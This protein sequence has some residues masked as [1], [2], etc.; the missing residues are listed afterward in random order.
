MR[1]V[2][3][4]LV[5]AG[6]FVTSAASGREPFADPAQRSGGVGNSAP[7]C[8]NV[9]DYGAVAD[10]RDGVGRDNTSAFQ[11]AADTAIRHGRSVC[12]PAGAYFLATGFRIEQ[13]D[14]TDDATPR[15]SIVGDG[16]GTTR[17]VFGPGEFAGIA[18]TA[19]KTGAGPHVYAAIRGLRLEKADHKGS[20]LRLTRTA[21]ISIE[22][23]TAVGW[24]VGLEGIDLLL[25]S[26][27]DV[28]L[29]FNRYGTTLRRG[30]FSQPN[31]VAF[32]DARID[33]NSECG[34]L[35]SHPTLLS[36]QGGEIG[37]NGMGGVS[38]RRGGIVIDG[39]PLEGGVGLV[40]DHAYFEGNAGVAD[41][42]ILAEGAPGVH[43]V[44]ASTF[45][46][47]SAKDFATNMIRI[48]G[49]ALVKVSL[50]ANA[51]KRLGDYAPNPS[52]PYV[53]MSGATHPG[54]TLVLAPSN[55]MDDPDTEGALRL[56]A[57][58]R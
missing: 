37:G 26:A 3:P 30:T 55:L 32:T 41:V 40:V 43:V 53:D 7:G 52:R 11:S 23:V 56:P 48:S 5:L 12:V 49:S 9:L 8:V 44:R 21:F 54:S 15:P 36:V 6:A 13:V 57:A 45:N 10:F 20:A 34:I 16:D 47:I 18:Y 58:R 27:R 38:D 14:S 35:A 39:G 42:L 31:A 2:L 17:L 19:G 1:P 28:S 29:R 4:I 24:K 33:S 50:E 25:S 22:R 46:R 51:F